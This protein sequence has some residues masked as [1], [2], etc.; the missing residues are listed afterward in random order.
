M[1]DAA[2]SQP[3]DSASE[4]LSPSPTGDAMGDAADAA[5]AAAL[6]ALPQPAAAAAG[7]RSV[8]DS[9]L[10]ASAAAM[11]THLTF[12]ALLITVMMFVPPD[13]RRYDGG[14][15]WN[16][17]FSALLQVRL[18]LQRQ[19]CARRLAKSIS[20]WIVSKEA[21]ET[22]DWCSSSGA[23]EADTKAACRLRSW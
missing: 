15:H 19:S 18:V 3:N 9:F 2:S 14:E 10:Q 4:E 11:A 21:I 23:T 5:A 20:C 13:S 7:K 6:V 12:K 16:H 1:T 17:T 8:F 22:H